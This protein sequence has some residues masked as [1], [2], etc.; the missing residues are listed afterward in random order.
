VTSTGPTARTAVVTGGGTGIG[1]GIAA[2]LAADGYRVAVLGRR[3]EVLDEVARETGAIAVA[4]DLSLPSEVARAAA[5][6]VVELGTVDAL[7][8]NAG[9]A[10]RGPQ[11]TLD[12]VAAHWTATMAQNL[13]PAVLLEHAL[14]PDLRRPGGRVIAVSSLSARVAGG[15]VAYAASKAALNRWVV[16][17]AAQLGGEG[18][19]VNGV[20]PGFVPDTGL[21]DGTLDPV[22]VEKAARSIAVRRVGTPGDI[23]ESVR[24]LA[25]AGSGFVNGTVVEVDGGR[26]A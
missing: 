10:Q 16:S 14:R 7:V 1:R 24:W 15:E 12:Q 6:V 13:L 4:A 25:S 21:Y 5:E 23:A 17:L 2:L 11:D 19:T 20:A 9:S 8:L 18:I 26:R 3:R 22:W